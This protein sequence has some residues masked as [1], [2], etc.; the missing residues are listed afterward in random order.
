[1]TDFDDQL[2]SELNRRA[3]SVDLPGEWARQDLLPSV[4]HNIETRPQRVA[5][6][7][8]PAF[9][10]LAAAA[11]IVLVLVVAMP[12]LALGP[13]QTSEPPTAAPLPTPV[14]VEPRIWSINEF[15]ES[16]HAGDLRGLTVVVEGTIGERPASVGIDCHVPLGVSCP[17]GPLEEADPPLDVVS[18]H[19]ATDDRIPGVAESDE[20]WAFATLSSGPIS[21]ELVLNVD[22]DGAVEYIGTAANEIQN[23]GTV[24]D[25]N[26]LDAATWDPD[27]VFFVNAWLDWSGDRECPESPSEIKGLPGRGCSPSSLMD[28]IQG[29]VGHV[30]V[31]DGAYPQYAPD[32]DLV[33]DSRREL[34]RAI[35]AVSTRLEGTCDEEPPCWLWNVVGRLSGNLDEGLGPPSGP[36]PTPLPNPTICAG[37]VAITLTD[38]TGLVSGCSPWEWDHIDQSSPP[39]GAS[40]PDG[41]VNRLLVTWGPYSGCI[42]RATVDFSVVGDRYVI[43]LVQGP[44]DQPCLGPAWVAGFYIELT[45]PINSSRVDFKEDLEPGW[46]TGQTPEPDATVPI[47]TPQAGTRF[48]CVGPP[49]PPEMTPESGPVPTLFDETGLVLSCRQPD[50]GV[51][52]NGPISVSQFGD[53]TSIYVAWQ[54]GICDGA[55]EFTLTPFSDDSGYGLSGERSTVCAPSSSMNVVQIDFSEPIDTTTVYSSLADGPQA[56][57]CSTLV[58]E[59]DVPNP[60]VIDETGLIESC[61]SSEHEIGSPFGIP[62]LDDIDDPI[63][64]TFHLNWAATECESTTHV[65]FVPSGNRYS[66]TLDTGPETWCPQVANHRVRFRLSQPIDV[67]RIDLTLIPDF[68]SCGQGRVG[69]YVRDHADI[70]GSCEARE[71]SGGDARPDGARVSNPNGDQTTLS[72]IWG[73]GACTTDAN[74]DL[75]QDPDGYIVTIVEMPIAVG[76]EG[77]PDEF[78]FDL[79]LARPIDAANVAVIFN[80][81]PRS[82]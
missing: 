36:R 76:C 57:I 18:R 64:R 32:P 21:G 15:S 6:S 67:S 13:G 48:D 29:P 78:G 38:E 5:T 62:V 39:Y 58:D 47:A 54:E 35:Y 11:A 22:R 30:V 31:Q 77:P 68:T 59:F 9:A 1:M 24:A 60:V 40:N 4:M 23:P 45:A 82:P 70:V 14:A 8:A 81:G 41:D 72:V 66:L 56:G 63:D 61:I 74:V 28:P 46:A 10:G 33:D 75:S 26:A 7:R 44:N 71:N 34:R 69:I 65:T 37:R 53:T 50:V 20:L 12:R 27:Q 55:I 79:H 80:E 49:L 17:M 25:V 19:I 52:R 3:D 43:H 42:N 51:Q 16:V 2:R 73:S